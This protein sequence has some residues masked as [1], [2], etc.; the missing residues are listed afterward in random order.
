VQEG[1]GV[2]T[3][4]F[5]QTRDALHQVAAHVLGR[6]RFEVTGRFGLRLSP[7]GIATPAFGDAE[8]IRIAGTVLVR[9]RGG[10]A[11]FMPLPGSTPR[12]L[13]AFVGADIDAPFTCGREAPSVAADARLEL[14]PVQARAIATWYDVG[15]RVL[16][17]V[18]SALP[19]SA[20][21]SAL[22][23]WPE[24]FDVGTTVDLAP[25]QRVNLGC[26]PGDRFLD[27]PYLYVGPCDPGRPGDP[28]YWNAPFGAVLA[29]SDVT[30]AEDAVAAGERFLRTGLELLSPDDS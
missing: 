5:R 11:T 23:L 4:G 24:H 10:T 18:L 1:D 25:G 6:R 12:A 2:V 13:A 7:D 22:Q 16:D 30:D 26:S 3:A 20:A 17:G 8:C 15:W 27:E 21:P 19:A 29:S 28:A 14:D 9:E